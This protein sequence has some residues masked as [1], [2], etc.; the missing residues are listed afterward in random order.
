MVCGPGVFLECCGCHSVTCFAN[1]GG[2]CSIW[3]C[4]MC[5]PVLWVCSAPPSRW[6]QLSPPPVS[7]SVICASWLVYLSWWSLLC[8]L[9]WFIVNL[10]SVVE[11]TC[12]CVVI[13]SSY[14]RLQCTAFLPWVLASQPGV[15][16]LKSALN[17]TL[18]QICRVYKT[19]TFLYIMWNICMCWMLKCNHL[20][21]YI[22]NLKPTCLKVVDSLDLNVFSVR[23]CVAAVL[24]VLMN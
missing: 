5:V 15:H 6:E 16:G 11:Q 1:T 2:V 8:S 3:S 24:N 13:V 21:L 18:E 20:N 17:E 4:V 14:C 7:G 23:P 22:L 9:C 19:R 10:F 12:C